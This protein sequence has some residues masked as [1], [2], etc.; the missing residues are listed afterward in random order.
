MTLRTV[1]VRLTAEIAD[2]QG[3][4]KAAGQSTRDFKGEIDKAA[5]KGN[6]DKITNAAGGLGL[7]LLGVAAGAVKMAADFDKSMSAVSAATHAPASEMAQL[8]AAAIQAGKDTQY[9]ATGA[10]DAIT[11]L[12]KAGVSTANILNGGLKGAL[13]LAAAGQLDVGEAAETAASAMT[14]F[15]LSGDQ[16]PH[17]ADLLA[18][19]AGKAQGSVHDVGYALNQS[20][21]VAAQFGL[22]IEDTTGA[23]AEFASAGLVGSD[24]G[25]SFKTMLLAMANPTQQTKATMN[26]LG[27]SFYDA[28]GKFIGLSGV[29][30]MLQ[31]QLKGLTQEQRNAAL[32]QIFGTDAIRSASILY[33]DGA[34]GVAK[35][36]GAVNDSGYAAETAAKL[37]DNLSG[38]LERLRGSLET[39]AIQSGGGATGGLRTLTQGV[40]GLVNGF[41]DLPAPVQ[42]AITVLSGVGGLTLLAAAGFLK[43]RG[44]VHD[45]MT[46]LKEMG[47]RGESA[48]NGLAKVGGVAGRL[49]LVGTA[50]VVAY[51]GMKAFGDWVDSHFAPT[52]RD[53]DAMTQALEDFAN[54]GRVT[55]ELA[56]T[57]GADMSGLSRDLDTIRQAQAELSKLQ[58]IANGPAG[59]QGEGR[60]I[61]ALGGHITDMTAQA[62]S[63][64]GALDQT[65]AD[66]ATNGNV[67]AAKVA[68]NDF[69]RS[70]GLSLSQLPKYA[71]AAKNA[72]QA[73]TGLASGFGDARANADTMTDSL[74][75]AVQA[76]QK[77]TDVWTELH[78]AVLSAD[79][80]N[81]DAKQ[82]IDA[83][84]KSFDANHKAIDGNSEAALKNRIAVEQAAQAASKSAEAKYEETGSV[85]QASKTYDGYISALHK[86]LTQSGLTKAQAD[87]L[88]HSYAT[89]PRSVTTDVKI[90]NA[91]SVA[92]KLQGLSQIQQDLAKGV[93]LNINPSTFF[94]GL[95]E[96]GWTGPGSKYQ[97]AGIVHADEYVIKASSRRQIEST[98]PGL[99][100]SMNSTG[101][102]G[103]AGGGHVWPYRTNVGATKIPTQ[104]QVIGAVVGG[105]GGGS[106][107][108]WI[109]EGI[110]LAG[111]PASWAGPLRTLIMRES[112]GNPRSINLWDSNA[113]AGHPSQGLMQ[114]IPSTFEHYRLRSLPDEITNPIA[115]IVAGLRYI[116]SR[117]GSIFNVQQANAHLPPKGYANGGWINEPVSGVGAS[118][119]RYTFGE[120]GPEYVDPHWQP[121]SHFGGAAST[122]HVTVVNHG[123]I[124]SRAEADDFMAGSIDRLKRRGRV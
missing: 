59:Q 78:G 57:F 8:R 69:A 76:G 115:N 26:S 97:P 77:L 34:A 64:I 103:Y 99:L 38:D 94:H 18:A 14:Q 118:G 98:R 53:I 120:R 36:K 35:W 4:L 109:R 20:G 7:G 123:V 49:T 124:G 65:L 107:G 21:L 48:A 23:L 63:D 30:Q 110:A 90:T 91:E 122:Y 82:A 95:A 108:A 101:S 70:T 72:S 85:A 89:M 88:I 17:V 1:G 3:K 66:L 93:K 84:K 119:Q 54:S 116:E 42:E 56:K 60:A 39:V 104:Q 111:V 121:S 19:A 102:V 50:G 96:G 68:F 28:Q 67:T 25:T 100:D 40:N 112:G 47:P 45:F 86:T 58:D 105:A 9:S 33:N 71:A 37:T 87:K 44:T 24:A 32:A 27:I 15:K 51:E 117:Y 52:T 22:S 73:S 106:L 79:Q 41:A 6:L 29:A 62:K 46:E 43:A 92:K 81:L 10:A 16:I 55:G 11:E 74:E 75:S 61:A 5:Q 83:V 2:Y 13:S 113:K 12:S 31:T 80:A 114:T